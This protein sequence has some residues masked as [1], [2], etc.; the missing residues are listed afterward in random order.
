MTVMVQVLGDCRQRWAAL[1]PHLQS[2]AGLARLVG[3]DAP[4]SDDDPERAQARRTLMHAL[5][6]TLGVVKRTQVLVL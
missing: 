5:T 2:A 3:L 4:P 1:S 6:L